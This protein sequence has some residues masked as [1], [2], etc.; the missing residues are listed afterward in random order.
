MIDFLVH[1][2]ERFLLALKFISERVLIL[3]QDLSFTKFSILNSKFYISL[4][5]TFLSQSLAVL[6]LSL[7]IKLGA[8]RL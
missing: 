7:Q 2:N 6:E 3:V 8:C 5:K 1:F 4:V